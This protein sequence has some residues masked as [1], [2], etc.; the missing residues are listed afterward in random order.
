MAELLIGLC[1]EDLKPIYR[2]TLQVAELLIAAPVPVL[3]FEQGHEWLFGDPVRFQARSQPSYGNVVQVLNVQHPRGASRNQWAPVLVNDVLY[4]IIKQIN[5]LRGT[6][7]I[8]LK[9]CFGPFALRLD[10]CMLP[11]PSFCSRP[12]C[13]WPEFGPEF[14]Y[15]AAT[16]SIKSCTTGPLI[17][18][19]RHSSLDKLCG[20][21]HSW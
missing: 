15:W 16:M 19:P 8:Q 11:P 3:Y 7:P 1:G 4:Q 12:L 2:V 21:E 5:A 14:Q 17:K 13:V 9:L 18:R 6:S 10:R 20:R